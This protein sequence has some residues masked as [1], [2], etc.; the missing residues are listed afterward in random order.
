MQASNR[1]TTRATYV[2]KNKSY[3]KEVKESTLDKIE[4]GFWTAETA[5]KKL[6]CNRQ[7]ISNWQEAKE[8]NRELHDFSHRPPYLSPKHEKELLDSVH[9]ISKNGHAQLKRKFGDDLQNKVNLTRTEQN[10]APVKVSKRFAGDFIR[11]KNLKTGNA[12]IES[13]PHRVAINDPRHAASFA[14]LLHYLHSRVPEEQFINLDKTNY[15]Y[16]YAD[17]E[18]APAIYSGE[19]GQSLKTTAPD[20]PTPKGICNIGVYVV[21]S[22]GG[23]IGDIVYLI[24]DNDMKAGE[25]DVYSA[26]MLAVG[27]NPGAAAHLMFVGES[28][29][30]RDEALKWV[31]EHV[32]IPFGDVLRSAKGRDPNSSVSLTVDGDPRQL[33]VLTE[34]HTKGLLTQ[35]RFIVGKSPAS[36]TP[37]YQPLDAGKLFLATKRRFKTIMEE[38]STH[39]SAKETADL[40]NI[41]QMHRRRHPAKYKK[42]GT[43][44]IALNAYLNNMLK[45][46]PAIAS[47]IA[48]VPIRHVLRDSFRTTG[49]SPFCIETVRKKCL[50]G[51]TKAQ[52]QQFNLAVPELSKKIALNFELK[53]SD[54]DACQIPVNN[55]P[56]DGVLVHKRRALLLFAPQV[57]QALQQQASKGVKM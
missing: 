28:Y 42:D 30:N 56:K 38:G 55:E 46:L 39:L 37:I 7:T 12:E 53:E 29:P 13:N 50:Y 22:D 24:K 9:E 11:K 18:T 36:C 4:R 14:A 35:A 31:I 19:R 34:E 10:K 51:W 49:V 52:E 57:V 44:S 2:P 47:A 48:D 23:C 27:N 6:K 25:I 40:K 16:L 5:W 41:F 33:Q 54:F 17:Q 20:T 15:E 8:N 21:G 3:S 26:P 32:V 1:M 45:C 43:P